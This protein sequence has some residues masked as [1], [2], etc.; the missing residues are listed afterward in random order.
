MKSFRNGLADN[1]TQPI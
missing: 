1:T